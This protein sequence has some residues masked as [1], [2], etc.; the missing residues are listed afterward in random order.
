MILADTSVWIDHFRGSGTG[1]AALLEADRVRMHPFV[2]GEL[3]CGNLNNRAKILQELSRMPRAPRAADEEVRAL[4]E[5]RNLS[6][7][8][9][10]YTDCHLLASCLL[11]SGTFIWTRDR[12]LATIATE[13][14]LGYDGSTVANEQPSQYSDTRAAAQ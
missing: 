12:R 14:G 9:I 4:I 1:L 10:G 6:G 3:A 11:A 5:N 2:V 7:R 8:G 13:L